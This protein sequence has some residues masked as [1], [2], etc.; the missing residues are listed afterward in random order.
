MFHLLVSYRGW[1]ISGVGTMEN[2]RIAIF[3]PKTDSD[4]WFY[5]GQKIDTQKV[6]A[7]PALFADEPMSHL[8]RLARPGRITSI[9][10]GP[11]E[12]TIR[13][14]F[15]QGIDPIPL[16]KLEERK[17]E[18]TLNDPGW[19]LSHTAWTVCD[20]DLYNLLLRIEQENRLRPDAFNLDA[21][22]QEESNPV[23]V[24]MPFDAAFDAV[25]EAIKEGCR[26]CN[27]E[28]KRADD[29]W[30]NDVIIQDIVDLIAK[31]KIVICD[32]TGKNPN[33]FYEAGI[34]H[35]LGKEVIL[36]TQV[37]A[38]IPFDVRHRRYIQYFPNEQGLQKL[39]LDLAKRICNSPLL[40][41]SPFG[42]STEDD[43]FGVLAGTNGGRQ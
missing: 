25:Y 27:R 18:L 2:G 24:M 36:L 16:S 9:S 23:S 17:T 31:S 40:L 20:G 33:V 26:L 8:P 34:A 19:G 7:I 11:K 14:T 22:G 43:P 5:T 41:A 42:M 37:D 10:P 39:T 6:V 1:D 32:C 13:Y 21:L 35:T 38:D 15:D 30:E 29:F 12:T 3:Y 4:R 28:C